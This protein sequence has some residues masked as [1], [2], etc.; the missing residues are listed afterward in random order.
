MPW[1]ERLESAHP[2]QK[3]RALQFLKKLETI[4][5]TNLFD[6]VETAF[7]HGGRGKFAQVDASPLDAVF[8]LS[9]GAPNRGRFRDEKRVI[10]E[11]GK[12]SANEVPVH[13]IGAGDEVFPLLRAIARATGGTFVD[14][15][16]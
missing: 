15:F 11:I 2:V 12:L 9:D 3:L 4:S 16:E 6:A 7:G 14:A 5:Y 1:T 10:R 13:T 8:L